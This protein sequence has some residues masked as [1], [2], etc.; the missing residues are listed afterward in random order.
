MGRRENLDARRSRSRT[1]RLRRMLGGLT[2]LVVVLTALTVAL[3]ASAVHDLAFQLDGDVL[4]STTTSVGG[5]TQTVDWDSLFNANGGKK[6]PPAGFTASTFSRDFNVHTDGSFDT[7][8]AT[9]F[10]S[11]SKDTL[12]ISTGWACAASA[13]VNSKVDIMNAY[14]TAFTAANGH[15]ILYFGLE[16]NTNTGDGNVGFWFLQNQ[17]GCDSNGGTA[18]FTGNHSDGDLLIV[19]AFTNGGSVSTIDVYRWNGGANGSL[20]T[21]SV[22]HGVDCKN[23]LGQDAACATVNGSSNG[24]NG[25]IATPWTTANAK[26]GVGHSLRTSEFFEGGLD[27][28][29]KGL[30]NKCF[31]VFT[32][33]T[34]SSQSLTATIFDYAL[35]T[36]G[37]CTS[38]TVTTPTPTGSSTIIPANG[39]QT[40]S[41]SALVTVTGIDSFDATLTF[42]LCGPFAATATTRCGTGGALINTQSITANGTYSSGSTTITSAGR[43][44]WR[45][46]FSGD[47]TA[48]VPSSS[49][50]AET[51]CFVVKPRQPT[52]TTQ[53]GAGPVDFG[54]PVTDTATLGN[55]ANQPGTGG[56]GDGSID[57]IVAGAKAGGTISFTLYKD[58]TCTTVATG[59]G[60][61]FPLTRTVDG[62]GTYGPVSFTPD[63]PGTYHWVASYS[64][65]PPNTLA[66]SPSACLDT[67]EDVVVR[68]IS[69]EITTAQSAYP[70]DSATITSSVTGD[71]LPA[72]GTVVFRLYGPSGG[73]TA[74]V[75][76][77]AGGDVV[78]SGGLLYK[79]TKINIGGAHSVTTSTNNTSVPV[80]V[81][82]TYF[83]KVTYATSDTAHT[84]RQSFCAE[85]T[86]FTFNNSSGI[87]IPFP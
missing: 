27:L 64:G 38:T 13:N 48:G 78:G 36:L 50:S 66:S 4:A 1:R 20:G 23:T 8:D 56:L 45:A 49:D 5:A 70:N 34:R 47:S 39:T 29:A 17:V 14:S 12:P 71:N 2:G 33:D 75:N 21:T 77:T 6:V 25:T 52:L 19:S 22:A 79:Q 57:P 85:N 16:R 26:D 74:L 80:N 55:T 41:D 7:S 18:S 87:G 3:P 61:P 51:E 24:T 9:T 67:N 63:A 43:Y 84:G 65:N 69:T 11:G 44:C 59:T 72:N 46:N 73:N 31:N 62:N 37:E 40:T 81:T 35:G 42:H 58:D 82:G 83:W 15:Q 10:T 30:G 53:A 54:N 76:C 60:G 86:V 28:T 32:G 68:Q